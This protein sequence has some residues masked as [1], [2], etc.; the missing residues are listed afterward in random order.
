MTKMNDFEILEARKVA[1][2]LSFLALKFKKN[3]QS[4]ELTDNFCREVHSICRDGVIYLTDVLNENIRLKERIQQ[5][6]RW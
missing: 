4:I 6:K 3:P 1:G 2:R 5:L